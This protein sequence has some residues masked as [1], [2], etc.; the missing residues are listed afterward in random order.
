MKIQLFGKELEIKQEFLVPAISGLV[1]LGIL[2]GCFLFSGRGDIISEDGQMLLQPEST[3][4][5]AVRHGSAASGDATAVRSNGAGPMNGNAEGSRGAAGEGNRGAAVVGNPGMT[6]GVTQGAGGYGSGSQ[7]SAGVN[8]SD[9]QLSAGGYGSGSLEIGNMFEGPGS[10]LTGNTG[11]LAGNR[12]QIKVYVVGCV[13]KP[14]IVTLTKGQMIYDAVREAGGLTEDADADNINM[15]F[16]LNENVM[17]VIKSKEENR[18][19]GE[20]AV[21]YSGSGPGAEVIGGGDDEAYGR[22]R[23]K[24]VNINTAGIDEL[25]TLPG[26]G[27]AKARDIIAYR[28]KY[29]RFATIEDIM[30]VPGIKKN[31][32]ESIRDYITVD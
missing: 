6:A 11:Q 24:P 10:G 4:S 18:T 29:G 14:G 5:D 27:E 9:S 20:G 13:R 1:L 3:G 22:D 28:E 8:S 30:K 15:V 21:V 25:D 26:I 16:S 2:A 19:A 31:R 32:F 7:L 17:L 12:D 23:I